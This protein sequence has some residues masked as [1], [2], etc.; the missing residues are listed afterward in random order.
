MR[1]GRPWA[2]SCS[3]GSRCTRKWLR[4]LLPC[5]SDALRCRSRARRRPSSVAAEG[6]HRELASSTHALTLDARVGA[7]DSR[8]A[9]RARRNGGCVDAALRVG[10][11]R[12]ERRRARACR[13]RSRAHRIGVARARRGASPPGARLASPAGHGRAIRP[14]AVTAEGA[15]GKT[16]WHA[17]R[18]TLRAAARA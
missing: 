1:S 18:L 5:S 6:A 16:A 4:L 8:D 12:C 2:P 7:A 10:R 13:C 11:A 15:R 9:A 3:R 14:A 17:R